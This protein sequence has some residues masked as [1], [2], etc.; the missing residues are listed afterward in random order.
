M[1]VTHLFSRSFVSFHLHELYFPV[2]VNTPACPKPRTV[3]SAF[4]LGAV[5]FS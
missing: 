4:P 1:Q 2:F 5:Y 3:L